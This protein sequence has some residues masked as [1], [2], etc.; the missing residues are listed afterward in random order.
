ME[1]NHVTAERKDDAVHGP[2][3]TPQEA[4]T[5]IARRVRGSEAQGF[6]R[7]QAILRT[8]IDTGIDPEKVRW[9]VETIFGASPARLSP[10]LRPR[11]S[12][13]ANR[14]RA[15]SDPCAD[16]KP[17]LVTASDDRAM[18]PHAGDQK[19]AYRSTPERRCHRPA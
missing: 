4:V 1:A 2:T 11:R 19:T 18:S 3:L 5:S 15:L 8:S 7:E 10:A 9:C 14:R 6:D 12:A 16:P 17:A 13:L